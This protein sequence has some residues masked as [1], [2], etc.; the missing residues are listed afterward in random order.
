MPNQQSLPTPTFPESLPG[1]V[2]RYGAWPIRIAGIDRLNRQLRQW[3]VA[4]AL[5]GI[6][7]TAAV[8]L[9][10]C[11][12]QVEGALGRVAWVSGWTLVA[13]V[14][15]LML[16]P[17]RKRLRSAWLGR[18]RFWQQT[19]HGLGIFALLVFG[20]H[21]GRPSGG[22]LESGLLALFLIVSC[23][24][25]ISWLLN[26]TTPR[27]L[28]AV[29]PA[30]VFEAIEPHRTRVASEAYQLALQAAQSPGSALLGEYYRGRLEHFFSTPRGWL[31]RLS[32]NG[33]LRRSLLEGLKRQHRYLDE[34]GRSLAEQ[35]AVQ[36][37]ARDDLD[38]QWAL[39][40]RLKGWAVAHRSLTWT[41]LVMIAAHVW[42][43][44]RF[45][46]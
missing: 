25:L 43:A 27:R 20:L 10:W 5:W 4:V 39:Q 14:V 40:W 37:Q 31:Y 12:L 34:P 1:G 28:L 42:L 13:S 30:L 38:F 22:W 19:H 21:V 23:S 2:S 46:G 44:W 26:W 18:V 32:P 24:G 7:L 45:H 17:F 16:L 36:I 11:L 41:L 29:Q 35:L 33:R 8:A 9:W 3:G 6:P 15:G